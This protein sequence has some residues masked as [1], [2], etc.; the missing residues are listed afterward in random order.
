MLS[1]SS[2]FAWLDKV[3][4]KEVKKV[5]LTVPCVLNTVASEGKSMEGTM[6][7]IAK[8]DTGIVWAKSAHGV[9]GRAMFVCHWKIVLHVRCS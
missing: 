2:A 5:M 8:E 7:Y 3:V 1:F 4:H 9:W 6:L